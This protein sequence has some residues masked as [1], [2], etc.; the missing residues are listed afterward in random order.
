MTLAHW[1]RVTTEPAPEVAD[2]RACRT[3]AAF[4]TEVAR[5]LAFPDYF[6]HN[7][8]AVVDCLR[9]LDDVT[10]IVAH[11]EELLADEPP[12]QLA[13]LVD[14]MATAVD[15]G[16]TLT[17]CTDADHEPALRRRLIEA[18]KH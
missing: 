12:E 17:L 15:D 4:F 11:A 16:L 9:D 3:R 10:L 14:V 18:A 5:V 2:G 13:I 7:W 6:G 1:L 8:D